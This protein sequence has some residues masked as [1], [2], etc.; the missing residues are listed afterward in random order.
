M[1]TRDKTWKF[2]VQFVFTDAL[3]YVG[4]FLAL[5]SW[6]WNL[7]V[8]CMKQMA[9]LFT[10]FNHSTY[11]KVISQHL[12]ETLCVCHLLSSQCFNRELL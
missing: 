7:R 1:A 3:S 9:P 12:A 5:R 2:W 4:L 10:V 6:D 11:Q 8:A